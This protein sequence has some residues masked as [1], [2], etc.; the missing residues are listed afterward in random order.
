[1]IFTLNKWFFEAINNQFIQIYRVQCYYMVTIKCA[2][3][4]KA[5]SCN[6]GSQHRHYAAAARP[7][8]MQIL[9]SFLFYIPHFLSDHNYSTLQA[10]NFRL[11]GYVWPTGWRLSRLESIES[12]TKVDITLYCIGVELW[13]DDL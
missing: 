1:M 6:T 4:S 2:I 7:F 12:Y 11:K 3:M 8:L 9:I 13:S 10:Y 5:I